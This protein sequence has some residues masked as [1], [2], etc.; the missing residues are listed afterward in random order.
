M[1]GKVASFTD[2]RESKPM[3]GC[4]VRCRICAARNLAGMCRRKLALRPA[5]AAPQVE[6][7]Q[8]L[9]VTIARNPMGFSNKLNLFLRLLRSSRLRSR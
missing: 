8:A 2:D 4:P 6:K 9:C 1:K 3:L 7:G 5:A